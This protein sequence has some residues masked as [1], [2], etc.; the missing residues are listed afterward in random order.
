MVEEK[1][2]FLSR[3]IID[4]G[5]DAE[6]FS[7]FISSKRGEDMVNLENWTMEELASVVNEFIAIQSGNIPKNIS[8]N[9]YS[10]SLQERQTNKS[11]PKTEYVNNISQS[12]PTLKIIPKKSTFFVDDF[13]EGQ[14][15]LSNSVQI[16]I[17]DINL[18]L[19]ANQNWV[20]NSNDPKSNITKNKKDLIYSHNLK[21]KTN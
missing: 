3:K 4:E 17:K 1:Q 6:E 20:L 15:E 10:Q 8:K 2:K 16:E 11:Q 21:L 19:N 12:M 7:N 18:T 9:Q 5:Y 13:I 14:I